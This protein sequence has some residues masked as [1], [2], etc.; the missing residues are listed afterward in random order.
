MAGP[1]PIPFDC[2]HPDWP[3]V[4]QII[5]NRLRTDPNWK[6]LDKTGEGFNPY[7]EYVGGQP[8][9]AKFAFYVLEVFWQLV[10]DGILAPGT[11]SWNMDLPWFHVTLYGRHVLNEGEYQPYDPTAYLQR[12]RDKIGTPD[13]TVMAYVEE[14]LA[15]FRRRSLIAAMVMLGVAAERVFLLLCRS[16]HTALGSP[17]EQ[18]KFGAV[19]NRPAMKPK[20]DWLH[21]KILQLQ[22]A[23]LQG[24]PENAAL[25]VTVVYDL[26]RNQRNDLGHPRETPPKVTVDEAFTN[27]QIF[28]SYYETAEKVRAFLSTNKI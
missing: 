15:T 14:A 4:R 17:K 1:T 5:F 26:I 9:P 7:V 21:P 19:L 25:A 3:L 2:F 10:I 12:L 20:L 13:A 11:D 28:P 18:S 6:Q 24:F 23:G 16:T 27:L 22:G 8:E